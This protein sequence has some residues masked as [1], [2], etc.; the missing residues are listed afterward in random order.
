M[1]KSKKWG[2]SY[3]APPYAGRGEGG[4][5][6][7]GG[8]PGTSAST[9]S[10]LFWSPPAASQLSSCSYSPCP[11]MHFL[12]GFF[13]ATFLLSSSPSCLFLSPLSSLL[14]EKS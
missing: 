11:E 14:T 8:G 6:R 10:S 13:I 7:G 2:G 5:R 9:S 3:P 12:S 4:G 1:L